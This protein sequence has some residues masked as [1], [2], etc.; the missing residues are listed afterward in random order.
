[1]DKRGC[2]TQFKM[3]YVVICIIRGHHVHD[4][5][6][7]SSLLEMEGHGKRRENVGQIPKPSVGL[8]KRAS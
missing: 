8:P 7:M 5:T 3:P 4:E 2:R 1:M 6:Y